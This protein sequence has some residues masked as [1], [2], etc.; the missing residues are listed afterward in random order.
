MERVKDTARLG[1]STSTSSTGGHELAAP[2]A[3]REAHRTSIR[4]PRR[5]GVFSSSH[6]TF[7]VPI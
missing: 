4:D 7:M 3:G 2:F 1:R 6:Q 5:S